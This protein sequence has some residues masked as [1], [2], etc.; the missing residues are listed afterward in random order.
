MT[1]VT[2]IGAGN[3]GSAV[4]RIA[5]RAGADVQVLTRDPA[6]AA[7]VDPAITPG[8]VGDA[9]TGEIVVLALPYPALAEVADRYADGF[10]G[11]VVV[12]VTN[13][14]DFATFDALVVP[15]ASSATAELADR[16]PQARVLKAFNTTFAG[17]LAAGTVGDQPT[18]VLIAGDDADAKAAL[19]GVVEGGG[20]RAADAGP[21]RRARE[22]EALG[23]LQMTLAA[24]EQTTWA[25]GFALAR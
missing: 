2:I 20:L 11:K 23:F 19:A 3:I 5:L 24:S 14:V 4:A 7:A 10:A 8:T 13:P 25:G 12:D 15:A 21:L 1:S 16:L 17:A 9:V 18:T 22:L 6:A